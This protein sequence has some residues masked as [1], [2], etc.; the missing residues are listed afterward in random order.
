LAAAG[1]H[2]RT[3]GTGGDIVLISTKNVFAPGAMF[4]AYSTTKSASHQLARIASLI[5]LGLTIQ[6]YLS[7]EPSP[8]R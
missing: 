4:G 8:V 5:P 3:Q 6:E 1:R 7:S 2:F